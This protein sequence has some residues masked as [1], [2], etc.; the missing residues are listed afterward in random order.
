MWNALEIFTKKQHTKEGYRE[1]EY[2][3][4]SRRS[5]SF[6]TAIPFGS[7]MNQKPGSQVV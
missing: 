2:Y 3:L 5:D 4:V 7:T 6:G 1:G